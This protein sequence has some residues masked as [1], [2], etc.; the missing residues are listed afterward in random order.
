MTQ[1]KMASVLFN[2]LPTWRDNRCEQGRFPAFQRPSLCG[3]I[4]AMTRFLLYQL[5]HTLLVRRE[6]RRTYYS[7][8]LSIPKL[9]RPSL[10]LS[11]QA[12]PCET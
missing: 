7:C 2:P 4:T 6:K 8:D 3:G 1:E 5:K 12:Y 10:Y 11:T 9:S